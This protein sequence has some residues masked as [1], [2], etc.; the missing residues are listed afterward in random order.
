MTKTET[1][2]TST[3]ALFRIEKGRY[4]ILYERP[5]LGL[6]LYN[7]T[8]LLQY[9]SEIGDVARSVALDIHDQG[10]DTYVFKTKLW[11]GAWTRFL[12]LTSVTYRVPIINGIVDKYIHIGE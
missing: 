6:S 3:S 4:H 12:F 1:L 2:T 5:L 8:S 7:G 10:Y 11:S 9:S